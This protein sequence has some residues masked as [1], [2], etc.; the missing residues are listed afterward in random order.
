MSKFAKPYG[1]QHFAAIFHRF[2]NSRRDAY[3]GMPLANNS[4]TAK[5]FLANCLS[6]LITVSLTDNQ[7]FAKEKKKQAHPSPEDALPSRVLPKTEHSQNQ[8]RMQPQNHE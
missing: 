2:S 3:L 4:K 8:G 7:G 5:K 6:D 1:R